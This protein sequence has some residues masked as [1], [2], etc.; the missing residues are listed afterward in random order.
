MA[1][2]WEGRK[3]RDERG[4]ALL[5]VLLLVAVMAIVAAMMLDRLGLATGLAAN[6]EAQGAAQRALAEGEARVLAG[7]ADGSVAPGEGQWAVPRGAIVWRVGPGGNCFN[8]NALVL[9]QPDG[10]LRARPAGL[11]EARTL[12]VSLGVG[13]GQAGALADAMAD[14]IDSDSQSLPQG[15]EDSVYLASAH[16]YRTAGRPLVDVGELRAVRGM[17]PAL[18]ARLAPWLC[19][20]PEVGTSP[21]A[22]ASLRAGQGR[23]LAM[24]APEALPLARAEQLIGQPIGQGGITPE[25]LP[26][27]APDEVVAQDRW[28]RARIEARIDG[29]VLGEDV[30]ID[31]GQDRPKIVARAWGEAADR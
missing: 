11:M 9:A 16:P 21:V 12:M 20:L 14:W 3:R 23:L 28:L 29:R 5:A 26:G 7:L 25:D 15:A 2:L 10:S 1:D 19:A 30:L 22:L 17:T 27:F 4:A 18:Q 31:G 6:A 8:V 13:A 24:F